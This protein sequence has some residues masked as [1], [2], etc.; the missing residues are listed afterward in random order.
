[1]NIKALKDKILQLAVQGKL[2]EQ[3]VYDESASVLLEKIVKEKENL[4]MQDKTK[5]EKQLP[6]ITEDEIPYELPKGWEWV[7]H[8][9]ICT[10][11]QRGKSPKYSQIKEIP[12]IAQKC[13]QWTGFEFHKAQFI[14]PE[15]IKGYTEERYLKSGDLLWNSTGTGTLG[16]INVYY[17]NYSP[18]KIVVADSHVT[19]IRP[20]KDYVE[21]KYLFYWF[22]SPIVQS[23]IE[24][25]SAG[26]TNQIELATSTIK[27]YLVPLPPLIEQ[28]RIVEKV[29]EL[30]S[31]I[32]E[33]EN[34]KSELLESINN[35]RNKVLQEAVKGKL[36]PQDPNDEP[37]SILIG[38]IEKEKERLIEEGKLK[39]AKPL[40]KITEEETPYRLPSGWEWVRMADVIDV[41]DGTHDTPK[42][43]EKDGYP[44][45][46][47]KDFYSGKLDFS[48]T[49]Y[50]SKQDY[51]AIIKRSK[52]DKHDILFS[53]IGGNIGSM[54][55]IEDDL[56][57]AI[58]NVAL[59]KTYDCNYVLPKYLY[60]YL[61]GQ[62]DNIK[63]DSK[64]GA[65]SFVPLNL[66]RS[67]LFV[68]PPFT[69]QKRIVEKVDELMSL[70]DELE[71]NIE[72]SKSD[73]EL[74]MQS[75]LQEAFKEA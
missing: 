13:I 61:L 33:L 39:I 28:K 6:P 18:Y 56:E 50:I 29:D 72:Q 8:Y 49:Q 10:Y 66:L 75:V 3:N 23:E 1:M 53:M 37:A 74:L 38:K 57:M 19:V 32:D 65:Q 24:S 30:F 42:Y 51:E 12:V 59:F 46:T 64:G 40:S 35:T 67:Y 31:I 68:L 20:F 34:N 36:V 11:I 2:A 45:I 47:G 41:R 71:K 17:E 14:E 44:L 52:V 4:I 25:K 63:R 43:V 73:S 21:S 15:S 9:N 5:K 26:S 70:C 60:Y 62:V 16:R 22:S 55:L 58:K 54:V 7:R 27:E 69:E 48:K